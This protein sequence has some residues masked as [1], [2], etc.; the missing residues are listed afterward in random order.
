MKVFHPSRPFEIVRSGR[1]E[2]DFGRVAQAFA[3]A[4]ITNKAGAPSF[5]HFAKGG[6]HELIRNG[7]CAQRTKS[8]VGGI[9]TRLCKKRKDGAPSAQMAQTRI[10]RQR[11]GHPPSFTRN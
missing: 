7:V 8:R 3:L 4:D 5:A 10:Y 1:G 2:R 6:N 11:A 9:V